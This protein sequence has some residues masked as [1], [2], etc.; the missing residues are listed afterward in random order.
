MKLL[1]QNGH[2][3]VL[4]SAA[5]VLEE[6]PITLQNEIGH[7]GQEVI[8]PD[9]SEPACLKGFHIQEILHCFLNRGKGLMLVELMPRSGPQGRSDLWHTIFDEDKAIDRFYK[10]IDGKKA[11]LI[12]KNPETGGNHAYAWDGEKVF[13]PLGRMLNLE[14]TPVREAWVVLSL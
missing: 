9:L 7:D 11:I 14:Q 4:Y 10:L 1:K 12:G 6:N 13:D 5:M 2:K 8:Y 3:C